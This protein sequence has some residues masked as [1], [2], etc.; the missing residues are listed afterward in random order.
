MVSDT[1]SHEKGF[2]FQPRRPDR[3]RLTLKHLL[4]QTWGLANRSARLHC[5]LFSDVVSCLLDKFIS[6]FT[7]VVTPRLSLFAW[8]GPSF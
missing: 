5:G 7:L 3:K 8:I 2:D 4:S 6:G 1:K